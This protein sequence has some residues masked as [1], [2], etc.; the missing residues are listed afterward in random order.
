VRAA[1]DAF[2]DSLLP[3]HDV[4]LVGAQVLVT[5]SITKPDNGPAG[6]FPSQVVFSEPRHSVPAPTTADSFDIHAHR[7]TNLSHTPLFRPDD[8]RPWICGEPLSALPTPARWRAWATRG[9]QGR[10]SA[11]A[12]NREVLPPGTS[13]F[14]AYRANS[15]PRNGPISRRTCCGL[16]IEMVARAELGGNRR[17]VR[18]QPRKRRTSTLAYRS[19]SRPESEAITS[20]SA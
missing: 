3:G 20:S 1:G 5:P 8:S 18:A 7:P 12:W 16:P 11:G 19:H 17:R 10:T 15:G 13:R 2:A 9:H 6:T 14:P 4:W